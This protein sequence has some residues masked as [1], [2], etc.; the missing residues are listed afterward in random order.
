MTSP[1]DGAAERGGGSVRLRVHRLDSARDLP[2]PAPASPHAAGLDL[3][4]AVPEPLIL[5]PGGRAVVPTGLVVAIPRGWEGQ[6]RPRSGLALRHGI[7]LANAP[8]TVDSDFR[9]EVGVI[10]IH[11]G[12]EPF[13]VH[14]GDRVAQLV[15]APVAA[16]VEVEEVGEVGA[17]ERGEGGFG[18]TG[19][20]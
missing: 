6:I 8:G 15:L 12:D 17:T 11:L 16:P 13:T 1:P 3:R 4:A 14:R 2:L 20:E 9:G 5:Q 7:T 19:V 10:L 18:S